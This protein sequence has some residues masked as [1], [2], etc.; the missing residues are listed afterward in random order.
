MYYGPTIFKKIFHTQR[1]M[2]KSVRVTKHPRRAI[3]D[4]KAHHF[5]LQLCMGPR[6]ACRQVGPDS[7]DS[8]VKSFRSGLVNFLSTF[9]VPLAHNICCFWTLSGTFAQHSSQAL[10]LVDRVGRTTLLFFS[11]FGMVISCV[12]LRR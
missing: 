11:A 7:L 9:P 12:G 5:S 4:V 3:H 8:L 10:C 2:L 6:I 1:S